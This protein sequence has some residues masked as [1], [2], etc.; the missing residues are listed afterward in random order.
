VVLLVVGSVTAWLL[1]SNNTTS[2]APMASDSKDKPAKEAG[3]IVGPPP[4]GLDLKPDDKPAKEVGKVMGPPPGELDIKPPVGDR[5]RK[6]VT[7][8]ATVNDVAVG[9]RGRFLLLH[10]SR[11]RKLAV[12]DVNQTRVVKEIA[13]DADKI[14][15]TAG[16]TKFVVVDPNT[17]TVQRW[18]LK[19]FTLE[20]SGTLKMKVPPV[21]VAMGSSSDGPLVISGVDYPNLGETVFFDLQKMQRIEMAFNPHNFF[22][23]SPRVFLRASSD[24]KVFA[25]Q[26]HE[27]AAVQTCIWNEGKVQKYQGGGGSFPVP[28]PDGGTICTS[29]GR[30]TPEMRPLDGP[31]SYFLPS[32][33][34]PYYLS[35]P[36]VGR[37]PEQRK[38]TITVHAAGDGKMLVALTAVAEVKGLNPQDRGLPPI[39]K[40]IHFLP[41][42]RL[43]LTIPDTCDRLVLY[44]L[45]V[46]AEKFKRPR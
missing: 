3:K 14:V 7:L 42:A 9:G 27:S 21:A 17:Y 45:D 29:Q 43:L 39:D 15:L 25:C 28:A 18:S 32:H 37:S 6:V 19:T 38:G 23:T 8:P 12:F 24:G 34:G 46:E 11:L 33:Q 1:Y 41:N 40:R 13:L 30:F 10:L 36:D 22:E 20:A 35:L 4:G 16:R 5:E 2:P 44:R 31:K 26:A